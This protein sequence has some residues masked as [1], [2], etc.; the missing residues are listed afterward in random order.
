MAKKTNISTGHVKKYGVRKGRKERTKRKKR[1][2]KKK[3][4]KKKKKKKKKKRK[5]GKKNKQKKNLW[6]KYDTNQAV[7]SQKM[8]RCL[9][10]QI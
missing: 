5:K 3:E 6:S 7:Q 2:K 9:K 1:K 4:K 10:F 8:A